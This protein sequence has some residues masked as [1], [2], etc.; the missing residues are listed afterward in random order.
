MD[1]ADLM[2]L[3]RRV[4]EAV[5]AQTGLTEWEWPERARKKLDLINADGHRT[6]E[7]VEYLAKQIIHLI[8]EEKR[9]LNEGHDQGVGD[10]ERPE[11]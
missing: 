1:W 2:N 11:I 10:G 4:L 8:Q 5:W 9:A 7:N 3:K 6:Q